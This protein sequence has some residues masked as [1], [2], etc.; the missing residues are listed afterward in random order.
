[1]PYKSL[2]HFTAE[3][4]VEAISPM[5][6]LLGNAPPGRFI[7]RGHAD[8][9]WPLVPSVL[10]VD[11]A[12]SNATQVSLEA[13]ALRDFLTF[14][15]QQGLPIPG[16]SDELRA[17][18][19]SAA[20]DERYLDGIHVGADR[21]IEHAAWP[22]RRL[23]GLMALAQHHGLQTRML[24]WTKSP[25][26]AAYFAAREAVRIDSN[27]LAV[28]AL[29]F[30]KAREGRLIHEARLEVV[31]VPYAGNLHALAQ[32]GLFTVS[33]RPVYAREDRVEV[34]PIEMRFMDR[35]VDDN[36]L[37][38]M[39][40][41]S[42]EAPRLLGLLARHLITAA[43]MFPGYDGAARAVEEKALWK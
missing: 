33:G 1:M 10:R 12:K 26:V 6:E 17:E 3:S 29:D 37:F 11:V 41:P 39:V 34:E 20:D 30:E 35:K 21:L 2:P 36:P 18:L 38:K 9:A 32:Q 22:P 31:S 28:W 19:F 40:L 5:G 24:D 8:S 42:S 23:R 13:V 4:L 16:D 15:D 7:F 14:A 27:S 43:T 25:L